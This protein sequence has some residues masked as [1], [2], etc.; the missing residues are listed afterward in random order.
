MKYEV[1][2]YYSTF[3]IHEVEADSE[4]EAHAKTK[5]LP[6]NMIDIGNNL[7]DWKEADEVFEIEEH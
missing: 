1:R 2:R 5:E 7:L 3:V 6:I 4:D